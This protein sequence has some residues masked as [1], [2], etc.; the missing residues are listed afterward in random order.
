[1][2]LRLA[3]LTGPIL[4]TGWP[5]TLSTHVPGERTAPTQPFPATPALV[6]QAAITP[7]EG[8]GLTF[9]DRIACRNLI[10]QYRSQGI[11]TPPS[12]RGSI[13][14]PGYAGGINW[15][16]LA[17]DSERQYVVAAVNNIPTVVTLVPRENL[18][19]MKDSNDF[20]S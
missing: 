10:K 9:Y 17:F 3:V 7:E 1:M 20:Q 5:M 19:T 14:S 18:S 11:Y 16:G 8:W 6:S 4:S 12:L 13:E 15:G 2:G